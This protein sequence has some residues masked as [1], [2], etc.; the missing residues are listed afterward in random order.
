MLV[1]S[2]LVCRPK[3][4]MSGEKGDCLTNMGLPP[5]LVLRNMPA[6]GLGN[7]LGAFMGTTIS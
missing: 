3:G 6:I 7:S 5:C 2:D 4:I 1:T